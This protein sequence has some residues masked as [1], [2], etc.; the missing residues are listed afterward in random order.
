MESTAFL[1]QLVFK[2]AD[3]LGYK[4]YFSGQQ[5][6]EED[7]HIPF[8][9]LGVPSLDVIDV[10]YEPWHKDSDTMDKVSAQSLDI[11]GTVIQE[12]IHRL[13]RQ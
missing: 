1:R 10:E 8:L 12:S 6:H 2:A 4:A 11:V 7:D 9:K 5:V 3:D 13:E